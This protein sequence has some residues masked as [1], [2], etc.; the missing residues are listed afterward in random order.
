MFNVNVTAGLGVSIS[1]GFAFDNKGNFDWQYSYIVP[2]VDNT[3]SAGVLDAGICGSV[4]IT[5][6]E[7]VYDLYGL[8]SSVGVSGGALEYFGVDLVVLDGIY[9]AMWRED[10]SFDGVQ[11]SVG[12]GWGVDVHVNQSQTKSFTD[13]G[14]NAA[15]ASATINNLYDVLNYL[16]SIFGS[17]F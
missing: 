4:L 12:K 16:E 2:G 13:T 8:G 14:N 10:Q 9:D 11:V 1:S 3:M 15:T 17:F 5:K 6:A 7:T